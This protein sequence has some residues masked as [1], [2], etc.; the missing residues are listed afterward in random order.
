MKILWITNILFLDAANYVGVS[1]GFGGGWMLSAASRIKEYEAVELAVASVS[2]YVTKLTSFEKNGIKYYVLPLTG[3]NTRY[4]KSLE[5]LWRVVKKDFNPD[6]VHIHGTE[7]AHG[8]AYINACGAE[9]V[10]VSIQGLVSVIARYYKAD[11]NNLDILKSVTFRDVLR[12]DSIWQQKHKFKKRGDIET[13][14]LQKVSHIIG[15]TLWDKAHSWAVNPNATYHYCEETLRDSFYQNK[16]T[17]EECIPHTIFISQAGYPIKGL[18]IVLEAMP[19]ILRYYPD[20][21]IY[22]GG[23][24]IVNKPWYRISGYG[25][26]I[27]QLIKKLD[28]SEHIVFLGSLSE[29]EMCKRYLKSNVFVCPSAIENSPN[30]LGEAQALGM[31]YLTAYVGGAPD[32][33]GQNVETLYRFEEIEM[34][35][36][37]VCDVFDGVL[38]VTEIS[39]ERDY[40]DTMIDI[41]RSVSL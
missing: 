26:Y 35:A 5:E 37:K 18:H 14:I 27:R 20:T 17:Y 1:V 19:L 21:R 29:S 4:N 16:W 39:R 11:I 40:T 7:Y 36:Q 23:E 6:V 28:L 41:Y 34:L 25:R 22:V 8:L 38:S 15:R 30:S 3:D 10:L 13:R 31:P 2:H 12:W 32:M 33:V 9:N 24:D